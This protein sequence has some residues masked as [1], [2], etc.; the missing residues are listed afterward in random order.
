MRRLSIV[1]PTLNRDTTL[2]QTL[3]HAAAATTDLDAEIIVINDSKD[4]RVSPPEDLRPRVMVVDNPSSGAASARNFGARR[5][6]GELLL[7]VDNDIRISREHV[8]RALSFNGRYPAACLNLNWRYPDELIAEMRQSQLG[9][10]VI[11]TKLVDYKGWVPHRN[12]NDREI[13]EVDKLATFFFLIPKKVFQA[14]G[15]FNESFKKQGGEDDEFSVR[16]R[17]LG[18]PMYIDPT[19]YVLHDSRDGIDLEAQLRRMKTGGIN[20]RRGYELGMPDYLISYPPHKVFAYSI[21]SRWK[22]F[23]LL[24]TRL[25]P[26]LIGFDPLYRVLARFL[27]GTVI[28]EGYYLRE[29]HDL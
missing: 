23:L 1:I 27:M 18:I 12:W 17:K 7:F 24:L 21:L 5:A 4:S 8:E 9:R 19:L 28:F 14:V 10:L 16:L 15:G 11:E 6:S 29:K 20:R 25:V 13:F 2:L 3:R 22:R 26:N